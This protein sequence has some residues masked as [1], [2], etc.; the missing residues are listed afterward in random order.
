MPNPDGTL[1]QEELQLRQ[2]QQNQAHPSR[3]LPGS[4]SWVYGAG[5]QTAYNQ[6]AK[7]AAN[8]IHKG[9]DGGY[10]DNSGNPVNH[11]ANTYVAPGSGG[12]TSGGGGE[13]SPGWQYD[14]SNPAGAVRNY[15]QSQGRTWD[16]FNQ[17]Y[18][19]M[20]DQFGAGLL[21]QFL[22]QE[23][24]KSDT[25]SMNQDFG[26]FIGGRYNGSIAAPTVQGATQNLG[27]LNSALRQAMEVAR[28]PLAAMNQERVAAGQ[29]PIDLSTPAGRA[30]LQA[31]MAAHGGS[32]MGTIPMSIAGMM[33]D[34]QTQA[35]MYLSSYLPAL[36]PALSQGLGKI[37]GAQQQNWDNY[38]GPIQGAQGRSF[39]DYLTGS[40]GLGH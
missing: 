13:F 11:Q 20:L 22:A 31:Y 38:Q 30:A 29:P 26:N 1:T 18:N 17:A 24:G 14:P 36:G 39:L 28:G 12:D 15:L 3:G 6:Q 4:N 7:D 2:Q 37:V 5:D 27:V 10:Y 16:P 34:P 32:G 8:G 9:E 19:K 25:A 40:M 33:T 21:P 35:A 23:V